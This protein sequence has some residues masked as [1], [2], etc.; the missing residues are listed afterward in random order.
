MDA[1]RRARTTLLLRGRQWGKRA[2]KYSKGYG[3]WIYIDSSNGAG[4]G[5]RLRDV[6]EQNFGPY[7]DHISYQPPSVDS[8]LEEVEQS[9]YDYPDSPPDSFVVSGPLGP[10]GGGPGRRFPTIEDAECWAIDK[11]GVARRLVE[12]ELGG[13]WAFRVKP[14]GNRSQPLQAVDP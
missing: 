3:G 7:A 2:V 9:T 12:S 4:Q 11:Y 13:R 14:R 10:E 5:A 8:S 6:K 1:R